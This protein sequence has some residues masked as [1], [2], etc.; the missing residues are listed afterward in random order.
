VYDLLGKVYS[1]QPDQLKSAKYE[2]DVGLKV[3]KE[4]KNF[5]CQKCKLI[6]QA[7]LEEYRGDLCQIK[8]PHGALKFYED[9]LV[10]L[11]VSDWKNNTSCP[12]ST[13]SSG[14][15]LS[16]KGCWHC[17]QSKVGKT[18]LLCDLIDLKW[19]F[20]RRKICMKLLSRSGMSVVSYVLSLTLLH[21][22]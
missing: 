6:M 13:C 17:I 14:C 4:N 18:G 1:Q 11:L 3:L 2:I 16:N 7:T 10:K 20:V 22:G 5:L 9:G 8:S 21:Q 19:E 15:I 12:E